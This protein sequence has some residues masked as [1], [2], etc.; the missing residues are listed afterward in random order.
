MF[1]NADSP[2]K[3]ACAQ[4][5]AK[6]SGTGRSRHRRE[7]RRSKRPQ[8]STGRFHQARFPACC[9]A[10]ETVRGC[11]LSPYAADHSSN[12]PARTSASRPRSERHGV[13][14]S[15]NKRLT[16]GSLAEHGRV[17]RG[18]A[19]RMFAFLGQARIIDDQKGVG[20]ADELIRLPGQFLLNR[21]GVPNPASE[22]K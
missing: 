1:G 11:R 22:M 9:A 20:A 2:S 18:D 15:R 17:L 4:P 5:L 6:R 3:P 13:W 16:I 7:R 10:D 21:P 8:S 19:D 12:S 14:A